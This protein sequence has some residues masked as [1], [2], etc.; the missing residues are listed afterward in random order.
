[1]ALVA[2]L[3][4][5]VAAQAD[6]IPQPVA[7]VAAMLEAKGYSDVAVGQRV[8][9]G[10]VVQG[11][12]GDTFLLLTILRDGS[13]LGTAELFRDANADG[14]FANDEALH[15]TEV[16]AIAVQVRQTMAAPATGEETPP[17]ELALEETRLMPGFAQ[18]SDP[19]FAGASLRTD[20]SER[21]WSGTVTTRRTLTERNEDTEGSAL[22]SFR[23]SESTVLAGLGERQATASVT[24]R[25]GVR[26]TFAPLSLNL[27]DA[28]AIRD[29][30]VA[31]AP[32]AEAMR[33]SLT[34]AAPDA[35]ALQAA[36]VSQVPTADAIRATV[37][38]SQP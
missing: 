13:T 9:G 24:E 2:G 36:I 32:D 16:A 4:T 5:P 20:A 6:G 12:T 8:F 3:A 38:A 27:P 34:A 22:R 18:R 21:L 37:V 7:A 23:L 26:G 25:G 19:L 1:M 31:N 11:R 15:P 17:V 28:G 14:V 35:E 30:T 10:Y 29:A 33:Q